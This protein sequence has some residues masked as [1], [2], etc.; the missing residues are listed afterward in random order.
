[1]PHAVRLIAGPDYRRLLPLSALL[2][3]SVLIF[4]DLGARTILSPRELPIGVITSFVGAPLF[5]ALLRRQRTSF[6]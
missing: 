6:L 4:A 3:A 1:V 5:L 2:G